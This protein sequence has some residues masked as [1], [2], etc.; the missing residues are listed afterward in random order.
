MKTSP[1]RTIPSSG[2]LPRR[3]LKLD[4]SGWLPFLS[5]A[6]GQG[7]LAFQSGAKV[8][9]GD[10]GFGNAVQT[11]PI[12]S[13]FKLSGRS[14]WWWCP[15]LLLV[16]SLLCPQ[17][18]NAA[19]LPASPCGGMFAPAGDL[20]DKPWCDLL[21]L[22]HTQCKGTYTYPWLVNSGSI[23][24]LIWPLLWAAHQPISCPFSFSESVKNLLWIQLLG[25]HIKLSVWACWCPLLGL[26]EKTTPIYSC[27]GG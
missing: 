5:S 1:L 7:F 2:L 13:D 14:P 17:P 3:S 24:C 19:G 12:V 16:R 9:E 11:D 18:M 22:A 27:L 23:G 15:P 6:S 8:E 4:K 25:L 20:L 10:R 26:N 21:P